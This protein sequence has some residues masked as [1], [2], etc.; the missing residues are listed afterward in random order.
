VET[1]VALGGETNPL[2]RRLLLLTVLIKYLED[3]R[4]F[5]TGW[6]GQFCK[7]ANS[8][9]EA[10]RDGEPSQTVKLLSSLEKRFNG[11]IFSLTSD[12]VTKMTKP[13]LSHF[14]NLVEAKTLSH[15][16]YLWEQFSFEHIPVEIVS[17]LYQRFVKGG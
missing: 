5:P 10:L 9:F 15:Q 4:V 17:H 14:A 1:D 3:R 8:F 2:L 16:R 13:V 7:G 6:F 11:N 12:A